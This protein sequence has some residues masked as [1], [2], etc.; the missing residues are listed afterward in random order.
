MPARVQY[1]NVK[2]C[3]RIERECEVDRDDNIYVSYHVI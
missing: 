1:T 2:I 3:V